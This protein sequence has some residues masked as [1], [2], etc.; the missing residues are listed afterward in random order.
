LD[1]NDADLIRAVWATE[2]QPQ[3]NLK[4]QDVIAACTAA[5]D[6]LEALAGS[7]PPSGWMPPSVS[8]S[9]GWGGLS[10]EERQV[11]IRVRV[12]HEALSFTDGGERPSIS[13]AVVADGVKLEAA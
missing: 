10:S 11:L 12:R 9:I 3:P 4:L 2:G 1:P 5:V 6:R 7:P 13:P 8:P